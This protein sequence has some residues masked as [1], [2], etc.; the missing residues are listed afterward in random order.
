MFNNNFS[1]VF[2]RVL[3]LSRVLDETSR[4]NAWP[5]AESSARQLWFPATD[6]YETDSAFVLEADLPGVHLE[7]IDMSF[8]RNTLTITGT[9]AATLPAQKDGQFRVFSAER[10]AGSFSRSVRLPEH[11]EA[12][13]IEARLVNG[14]LTVTVPK[15]AGAMPRKITINPAEKHIKASN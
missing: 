3:T 13:K 2:D 7:N 4:E 10:T 14:V 5:A 6:I 12:D 15:A 9:R 8:E 1:N 11:V